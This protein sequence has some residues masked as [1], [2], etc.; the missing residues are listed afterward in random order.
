MR[1]QILDILAS[2]Y[3][4]GR[5]K[6]TLTFYTFG[7]GLCIFREEED[8][9]GKNDFINPFYTNHLTAI[10]SKIFHLRVKNNFFNVCSP[11]YVSLVFIP[12][13]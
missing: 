11:I 13:I 5:G 1:C 10:E 6:E 7:K 3:S 9:G 2:P 8:N 12:D 4:E